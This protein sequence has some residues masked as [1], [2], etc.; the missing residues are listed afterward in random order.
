MSGDATPSTSKTTAAGFYVTS[1]PARIYQVTWLH[2]LRGC[3]LHISSSS[4][5][6][7]LFIFNAFIFDFLHFPVLFY[8]INYK[9]SEFVSNYV[10]TGTAYEESPGVL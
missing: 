10:F 7:L 6:C 4:I 1:V 9:V 5:L 2:T 3:Y 8:V